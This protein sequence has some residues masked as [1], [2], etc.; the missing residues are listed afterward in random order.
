M[1]D[2][3]GEH[4]RIADPSAVSYLKPTGSLEDFD[5]GHSFERAQR[6]LGDNEGGQR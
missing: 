4:R 2:R 1:E 5:S 3:S 6:A